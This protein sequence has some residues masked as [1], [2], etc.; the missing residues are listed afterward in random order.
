MRADSSQKNPSFASSFLYPAGALL[1]PLSAPPP[2]GAGLRCGT[3]L[4]QR[5]SQHW[6]FSRKGPCVV[7]SLRIAGSPLSPRP[8]LPQTECRKTSSKV[9]FLVRPLGPAASGRRPAPSEAPP[10]FQRL[11]PA[12]ATV[13]AAGP[14]GAAEVPGCP[15]GSVR[16]RAPAMRPAPLPHPGPRSDLPVSLL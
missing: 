3:S 9:C 4:L 14:A 15:G 6:Q 8:R 16:K 10:R 12:R 2:D 5:G 11:D 7:P 1:S 13:C